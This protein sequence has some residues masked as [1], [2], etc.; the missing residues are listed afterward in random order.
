M[1]HN[2]SEDYLVVEYTIPENEKI[3]TA[4]V[5][6][7]S[8]LKECDPCDLTPLYNT[9]DPNMLDRICESQQNGAV[10]FVY[11]GF[12]ITVEHGDYLA[13]REAS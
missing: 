7:V 13:L 9:I 4:T 12:H 5:C 2:I 11:S 1:E 8:S 10:Q 3:S 6:A